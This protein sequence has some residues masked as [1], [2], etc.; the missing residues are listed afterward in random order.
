[1]S[2]SIPQIDKDAGYIRAAMAY[3]AAG[4]YVLPVR[5]DTKAPALGDGWP[6]KTSRDPEQ[7][8]EWFAGTDYM[9]A[10]HVGRSGAIAI[11]ADYPNLLPPEIAES[12]KPNVPY[13]ST[14]FDVPGRG[15]WV[16]AVPEG[17]KFGNSR[18]GFSDKKWGEIRGMNGIIVVEPSEHTQPGGRYEW[19]TIGELPVLPDVIANGLPD[20]EDSA[21]VATDSEIEKFLE[22]YTES[23]RPSLLKAVSN[24]FTKNLVK[25][26]RHEALVQALVWGMREAKSGMYPARLVVDTLWPDF[27]EAMRGERGRLPKSEFQGVLAWAIGQAGGTDENQRASEIANRIAATTRIPSESAKLAAVGVVVPD[28]VVVPAF[29]APRDIRDYFDPKDGLEAQLL[30]DD[31]ISLGPLAYGVDNQ[32]WSYE[33]GVWKVRPKII[34]ARCVALLKG[35]FRNAHAANVATIV[36]HSVEEITCEPVVDYINFKDGMVNWRTGERLPHAPHYGSTVQLP[37]NYNP[38]A[39]CPTFEK[40]LESVL[41]PDYVKYVWEM[42]GYLMMNGNPLQSAFMLLGNG[43]NGKGTLMRVI[44]DLLGHENIAALSLDSLTQNRFAPAG[45]FGKVANIAGD[46][47]ATYQE[48]T[49]PFK[50]LTGEDTY[51]GEHKH[52]AFFQFR[53]W[54]V[55]VFSANKVPGS[56]DTSHGYLRR[57]RIIEFSREITEAEKIPGFSDI[58]SR[59]LEGIA[60]KGLRHLQELMSRNNNRGGFHT[61]E[62]IVKGKER[63]AEAIDQVRQW[64]DEYAIV[65]PGNQES[66]SDCY[67]GYKIWAENEGNKR[68]KSAEFAQRLNNVT[69]ITTGKTNGQRWVRGLRIP[70]VGLFPVGNQSPSDTHNEPF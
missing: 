3:A 45:L 8:V 4:W 63:F 26:S 60:A 15:H 1:M 54:A 49:A 20:L 47:D 27:Q 12:L 13:Q 36:E 11:D 22:T 65:T 53:S 30:A 66:L 17:R 18:G 7:I 29:V 52:G 39:T 56:S 48:N 40:F 2:L 38:D 41:S 37:V 67:K 64:V 70:P 16:F 10:L 57:W 9:L 55:P 21:V 31:V 6:S 24:D 34:P 19:Q 61:S 59:E 44:G 43:E 50:M 69:G 62:E 42:I 14:R 51:N 25:G 35:R 28:A 68:M 33:G 32:F 46:I 5:P 23:A 58:L